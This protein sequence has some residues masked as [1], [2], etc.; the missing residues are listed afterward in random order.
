[1]YQ[2]AA[3]IRPL[4]KYQCDR[5]ASIWLCAGETGRATLFNK[6]QRLIPAA[7]A[8]PKSRGAP[9]YTTV[10]RPVRARPDASVDANADASQR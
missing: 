6:A 3:A 9:T 10:H 2:A 7:T 4:P 8:A 1:V 5:I